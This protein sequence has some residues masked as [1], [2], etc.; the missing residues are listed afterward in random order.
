MFLRKNFFGKFFGKVF[1]LFFRVGGQL[2]FN[3]GY[4]LKKQNLKILCNTKSHPTVLFGSFEL[5]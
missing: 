2:L 5:F 4:T 3:F 1:S